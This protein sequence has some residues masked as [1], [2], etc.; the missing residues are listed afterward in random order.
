MPERIQPR[1]CQRCE[2]TPSA[3]T[4]AAAII[5]SGEEVNTVFLFRAREISVL[6]GLLV[7]R[8]TPEQHDKGYHNGCPYPK[9]SPFVDAHH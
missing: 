6:L 3:L 1:Q 5:G 7:R 9:R 4:I 8:Y 2:L